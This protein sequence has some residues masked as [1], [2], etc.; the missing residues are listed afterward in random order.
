MIKTVKDVDL[1]GKRIIMRVDFN[2]PM[3]DGVV[4][5]DTRIQAALPT[6]KYIIEQNGGKIN[7]LY[8]GW[9]NGEH[10]EKVKVDIIDIKPYLEEVWKPTK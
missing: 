6:I 8:I 2:V 1:K 7:H 4:Q 5:D 10:W 9:L 3:K